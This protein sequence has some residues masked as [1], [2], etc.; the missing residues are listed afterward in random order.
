M[1]RQLI[2]KVSGLLPA[3]IVARK[4]GKVPLAVPGFQKMA[5]FVY[6]NVFKQVFG[7]F[8][9]FRVEADIAATGGAASPFCFHFLHKKRVYLDAERFFPLSDERSEFFAEQGLVPVVHDAFPA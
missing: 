4:Q 3:R 1:H 6:D 2:E 9:K 5:Q 7:L 8:Y